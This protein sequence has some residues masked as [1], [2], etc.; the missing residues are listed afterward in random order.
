MPVGPVIT[1]KWSLLI[2]RIT[3]YASW[4]GDYMQVESA[5]STHHPLW[6]LGMWTCGDLYVKSVD[7]THHLLWQLGLR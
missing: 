2:L 6:Q 4:A 5:D 1:C 3:L 7:S